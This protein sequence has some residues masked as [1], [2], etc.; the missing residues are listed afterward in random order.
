M[1]EWTLVSSVCMTRSCTL[2][3]QREDGLLGLVV[4]SG[5]RAR[6]RRRY[7]VWDLPDSAPDYATEADAS[8][9]LAALQQEVPHES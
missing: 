8:A 7:F 3:Y 9:A 6:D 1:A 5:G 2:V 4:H